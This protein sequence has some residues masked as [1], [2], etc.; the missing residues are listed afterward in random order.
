MPDRISDP[1][2]FGSPAEFREWLQEHHE[3]VRELWVGFHK[4]ATGRPSLTWS[5]S[6][7]EALCFGWIDGI[8][9]SIGDEAYVIRFTPRKA[10]SIWSNI[11][12]SAA[13]RRI[14]QLQ[15]RDK[16]QEGRRGVTPRRPLVGV[17]ASRT[18][19]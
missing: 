5:E 17:D 14:R 18:R 4:K 15:S 9:K 11:E 2:Y 1:I 13:G 19:T 8:R 16:A 6:V 10:T 3:S 12:G 7:D